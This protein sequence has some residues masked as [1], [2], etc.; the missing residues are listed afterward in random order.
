MR[1]S[2]SKLIPAL[3]AVAVAACGGGGGGGGSGPSPTPP[4]PGPA[5]PGGVVAGEVLVRLVDAAARDAVLAQYGLV[6]LDQFGSRPIYRTRAPA[7][8]ADMETLAALLEQDARVLYA[9]PNYVHAAP[10]STRRSA[11]AIGGDQAT[12]ATQWNTRALR[13]PQAHAIATGSGV[14]VAVLDTGV[15]A[16]HPA[17]AGRL[18]PG[19]DFVDFD[20]DPAERGA[21]GD[22]G[23]GHGTHVASLVAQVAPQARILPV[24]VLDPQGEGNAWVLAEALLYAVDPDG[25]PDTDDGA[26]VIN[27]S[28]GTTRDADLLGDIIEIV[29]CDDDDTDADARRCRNFGGAVVVSAA[30]NSGDTT[31]HYPA[32]EEET[33]ALAVTASTESG[34]LASFS[35]RGNW[36]HVAAPGD[37]I[38][39]AV[40]GG[41]YGVWSGTSMAAPMVAGAAALLRAQDPQRTI[42]SVTTR[43]R[44]TAVTLCGSTLPQIDAAAALG[45]APAAPRVCP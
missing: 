23:F 2:A 34:A 11:W 44:S 30:G 33:G 17:L 21:P 4:A 43:L 20:A 12:Y 28:L 15:D 8:A 26:R 6:L 29:T 37:L 7:G 42:G 39:G 10:E 18:V 1:R 3:F 9:E 16:A 25:N 5:A 40:P 32:A 38:Y 41:A 19:F 36:V 35:T 31:P 45:A 22:W 24:R 27:M 14:T 13:L